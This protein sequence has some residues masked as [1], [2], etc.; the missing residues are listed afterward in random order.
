MKK[1]W[2]VLGIAGALTAA[3]NADAQVLPFAIEPKVFWANPMGDFGDAPLVAAE[4][5]VGFGVDVFLPLAPT[6]GVYGGWDRISFGTDNTRFGSEDWNYTDSGFHG[7]GV[8]GVPLAMLPVSP[9]VRIGAIYR[10]LDLDAE[11]AD[12]D[13]GYTDSFGFEL[14]LGA[15]IPLGAVLTVTPE[16]GY[17][18]Y[19]AEPVDGFDPV[20]NAKYLTVGAGVKIRI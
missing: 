16:V 14:G 19:D 7:G 6:I 12:E 13:D 1:V 8:F 10:E 3:G 2:W 15:D 9:W 4:S 5:G 11:A 18:Q 17:R 20:V